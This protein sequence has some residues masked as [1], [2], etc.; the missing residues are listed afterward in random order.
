MEMQPVKARKTLLNCRFSLLADTFDPP[1]SP[2]TCGGIAALEGEYSS[3]PGLEGSHE[4]NRQAVRFL[5]VS[6]RPSSGET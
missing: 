1:F 4:V 2:A 3:E 5:T 6:C